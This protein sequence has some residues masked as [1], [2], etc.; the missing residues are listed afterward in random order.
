MGD[1]LEGLVGSVRLVSNIT[2]SVGK[3][4]T[5]NYH[6]NLKIN[7]ATLCLFPVMKTVKLVWDSTFLYHDLKDLERKD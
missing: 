2:Q 6:T 5:T 3:I 1:G 4:T 7:S